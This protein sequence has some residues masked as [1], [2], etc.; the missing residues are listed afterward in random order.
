M[1][2]TWREHLAATGIAVMA[3]YVVVRMFTSGRGRVVL[4][5]KSFRTR[6]GLHVGLAAVLAYGATMATVHMMFAFRHFVPYLA[7]R[8]S[9]CAYLARRAGDQQ[10][11]SNVALGGARRPRW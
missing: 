11:K 2:D 7:L 8:R 3:V 5:L 9:L 4:L 6:W 10:P 1:C